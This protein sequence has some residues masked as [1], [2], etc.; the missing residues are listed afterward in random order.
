[1]PVAVLMSDYDLP[2]RSASG[3]V[4]RYIAPRLEPVHLYAIM[5]RRVPFELSAPQSDL[6]IGVGHGDEVGFSGQNEAVILE[7]GK[8]NPV[9]VRGKVIK[10]LSCQTGIALGPDLVKNGAAAFLGYVDD[11][12]W[13]CDADLASTPWSDKM[14]T[15]CLM[16]VV[17]SLN[18]L[19]DGKTCREAF[20]IELDGYSRN[21]EVEED[22]LAKSCLEFNRE[23]A[24]LLGDPAGRVRKRPK[25]P[26]PFRLVPPPPLLVPL[27]R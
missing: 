5:A 11:Y 20:Q 19:L 7:V 13:L 12:V 25:L 3:F 24:V 14:A 8:Y 16:P 4:L 15:A 23:N 17:D 6:I 10:L 2:T 9:E 27:R 18:A 22:E 21:A 26:L 1:M